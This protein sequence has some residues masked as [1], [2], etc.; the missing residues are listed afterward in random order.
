[1]SLKNNTCDTLGCDEGA[2][3]I[4]D[5]SNVYCAWCAEREI[6]ETDLTHDDF[7]VIEDFEVN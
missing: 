3:L 2:E 7:D 1:M 5:A 4:D 6:S